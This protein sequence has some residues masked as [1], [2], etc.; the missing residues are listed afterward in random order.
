MSF[1]P[2]PPRFFLEKK[3][4]TDRGMAMQK[5]EKINFY[6]LKI[7]ALKKKKEKILLIR[8]MGHKRKKKKR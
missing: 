7:G 2:H 4:E 8:S 6:S 3:R 5:K 1:M